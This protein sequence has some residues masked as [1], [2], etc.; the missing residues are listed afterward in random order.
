M[1]VLV[2]ARGHPC[3]IAIG[4]VAEDETF[5]IQLFRGGDGVRLP[6]LARPSLFT[7]RSKEGKDSRRRRRQVNRAIDR[8]VTARG[9]ERG[10][11]QSEHFQ[12]PYFGTKLSK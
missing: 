11:E 2:E 1:R 5:A 7:E 12:P 4:G 6:R 10:E 3:R 8:D 9:D